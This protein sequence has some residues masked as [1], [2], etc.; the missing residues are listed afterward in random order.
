MQ[1]P[2]RFQPAARP[3]ENLTT[4]EAAEFLCLHPKTLQKSRNP[5]L[6][7][8][9]EDMHRTLNPSRVGLRR[10]LYPRKNLEL[11]LALRSANGV[12]PEELKRLKARTT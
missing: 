10:W 7:P 12:S 2:A 11:W 8:R 5:E 1:H 4:A 3:K 6:Y 9:Y